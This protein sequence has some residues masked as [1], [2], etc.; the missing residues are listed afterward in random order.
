MTL[1]EA[2]DQAA[3]AA[4]FLDYEDV[5]RSPM[6]P[7]AHDL[8]RK[9]SE[10]MYEAGKAEGQLRRSEFEQASYQRG[11][12]D[13]YHEA[14]NDAIKFKAEAELWKERCLALDGEYK[15]KVEKTEKYRKALEKIARDCE[16]D[17][18]AGCTYG[19]TDF[20]SE[21]YASGYNQVIADHKDI[22]EEALKP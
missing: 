14:C 4:G 11:Q 9:M 17:Y 20:D 21:S 10:F 5:E 6:E 22:A 1:Q 13:G 16:T 15:D 12:D 3:K 19:N 8:I 2:K 7:G 18:R